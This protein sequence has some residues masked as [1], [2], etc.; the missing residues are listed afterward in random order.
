[1]VLLLFSLLLP[2][3]SSSLPLPPLAAAAAAAWCRRRFG[4]GGAVVVAVVVVVV[5]V[6]VAVGVVVDVGGVRESLLLLLLLERY[7]ASAAGPWT[8]SSGVEGPGWR[9]FPPVLELAQTQK[10][11][12]LSES[13]GRRRKRDWM[14]SWRVLLLPRVENRQRLRCGPESVG[15]PGQGSPACWEPKS[16]VGQ[17]SSHRAGR[18]EANETVHPNVWMCLTRCP[19]PRQGSKSGPVAG[20][21]QAVRPGLP[22]QGR[23]ST[24]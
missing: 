14:F 3:S 2:S 17:P 5:A 7:L 24:G 21:G 23:G 16:S 15:V 19:G 10:K 13:A 11:K 9:P 1:M 6:V 4:G 8:S 20:L 18:E 22:V 12:L